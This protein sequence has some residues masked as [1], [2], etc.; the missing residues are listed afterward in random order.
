MAM[1][2]NIAVGL[3]SSLEV[4]AGSDLDSL[5]KNNSTPPA[6]CANSGGKK[7]T[8][9]KCLQL[10]YKEMLL[11]GMARPAGAQQPCPVEVTM[12]KVD[13]ALEWYMTHFGI[14]IQRPVVMALISLDEDQLGE[15]QE[16]ATNRGI[17]AFT[18]GCS[19]K[20]YRDNEVCD[21][22]ASGPCSPEFLA[23][24]N[25]DGVKLIVKD[26]TSPTIGQLKA[27]VSLVNRLVSGSS[28]VGGYMHHVVTHCAG[29]M[30][31]TG[32]FL[33]VTV[34][35]FQLK[36]DS[37]SEAWE[38]IVLAMAEYVLTNYH[39]DAG[40]FEHVDGNFDV[41]IDTLYDMGALGEVS[42]TRYDFQKN[43]LR[44]RFVEL[45]KSFGE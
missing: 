3:A 18:H 15:I 10:P 32:L 36:G 28:D 41:L 40:E 11:C 20:C 8:N 45:V 42:N 33:M 22:G 34:T 12:R 25:N 37:D 19:S 44:P 26:F 27:Y 39:M 43:E 31:R 29:G 38:D 16:E 24:K 21:L 30:G 23:E 14:A 5:G 6:D 9:F 4:E 13:N 1:R 7:P 35:Y 2:S 17:A